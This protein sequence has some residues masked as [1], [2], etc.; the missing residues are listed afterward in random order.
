MD[1]LYRLP[2]RPPWPFCIRSTWLNSPDAPDFIL[3]R[4]ARVPLHAISPALHI[5]PSSRSILRLKAPPM[6]FNEGSI[7]RIEAEARMNRPLMANFRSFVSLAALGNVIFSLS[8]FSTL[9]LS[10]SFC[11]RSINVHYGKTD[12]SVLLCM[13][14]CWKYS[15]QQVFAT[16]SYHI[17]ILTTAVL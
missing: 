6:T 8:L 14:V 2:S 3:M 5:L 13:R 10:L 17:F 7:W 9:S 1:V 11:A 16:I 4:P 12:R 15:F